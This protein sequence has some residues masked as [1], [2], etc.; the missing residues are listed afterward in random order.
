[1]S[2]TQSDWEK[3]KSTY[4][5]TVTHDLELAERMKSIC[6]DMKYYAYI[7][8]EPDNDDGSPHYHFIVRNNGTR[9]VKQIADKFGI[10]SNFVQPCR[11]VVAYRRYLLHLDND[12]K[13]KYKVEDVHT[14]DIASIKS[15]VLGND[16]KDVFSLYK[17]F[18]GNPCSA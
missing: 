8:H 15:A 18:G 5:C 6:L 10:P 13:I 2:K 12:D 3:Q 11:K 1:M 14:N 4:F 17:L 16:V 7:Y 9:S